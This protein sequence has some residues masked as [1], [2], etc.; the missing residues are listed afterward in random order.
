M[1]WI[2]ALD[3][4]FAAQANQTLSS[5]TTYSVGGL[6]WTKENS[7]HDASPMAVVNGSGLI[8]Q[9]TSVSDWYNTTSPTMPCISTDITSF[10][11]DFDSTSPVRFWIYVSANNISNNY[12][13]VKAGI[14][15]RDPNPK[16]NAFLTGPHANGT[17]KGALA[18]FIVNN[19]TLQYQAPV[20]A[21]AD[22]FMVELPWGPVGLFAYWMYATWAG[23]WPA[24]GSMTPTYVSGPASGLQYMGYVGAPSNWK[25]ILGAQRSGSGTSLSVTIARIKLEYKNTG[26]TY[27]SVSKRIVNMG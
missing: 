19:G 14:C 4:D 24:I 6:T 8:I 3:L 7:V 13:G 17:N 15:T 10:L 16:T 21:T 2:T 12:D 20:A 27:A 26:N 18:A 1:S 25:I 9:P 23:Q 5:D 11:P 22:V